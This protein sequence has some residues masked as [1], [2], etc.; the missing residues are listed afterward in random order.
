MKPSKHHPWRNFK[1]KA[2][3]QSVRDYQGFMKEPKRKR[4][5]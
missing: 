4:G 1:I 3:E 2:T 5:K